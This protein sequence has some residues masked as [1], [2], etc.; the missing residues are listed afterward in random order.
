MLQRALVILL[1]VFILYAVIHDPTQAG[2]FT[3]NIWGHIKDGISAIGTFFDSLL[4]S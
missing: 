3:A 1:V 2:N 4:S